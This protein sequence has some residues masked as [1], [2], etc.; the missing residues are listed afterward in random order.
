[1][2]NNLREL[3]ATAV[4]LGIIAEKHRETTNISI[5]LVGGLGGWE[6]RK[7]VVPGK[8]KCAHAYFNGKDGKIC[9][10]ARLDCIPFFSVAGSMHTVTKSGSSRCPYLATLCCPGPFMLPSFNAK[11]EDVVNSIGQMQE[12]Q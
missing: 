7:R 9:I 11:F 3:L 4:I 1:M 10:G 5:V 2:D 8:S 12:E 6:F